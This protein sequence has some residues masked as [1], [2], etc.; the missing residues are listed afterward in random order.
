MKK[1]LYSIIGQDD[2]LQKLT[3]S[4]FD[5]IYKKFYKNNVVSHTI[6]YTLSDLSGNYHMLFEAAKVH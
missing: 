6:T 1:R 5:R 4:Y 2:K 3:K